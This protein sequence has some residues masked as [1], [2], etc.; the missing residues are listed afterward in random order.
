[1]QKIPGD[2]FDKQR[3]FHCEQFG[4]ALEAPFRNRT[5]LDINGSGE[6]FAVF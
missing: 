1:M 6:G 4:N 3:H 5:L 2:K